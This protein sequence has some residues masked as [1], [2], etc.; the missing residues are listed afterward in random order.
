[1]YMDYFSDPWN[2]YDLLSIIMLIV[3]ICTHIADIASHNES[4]AITHNRL[5][6]V[7]IIIVSLKIFEIGRFLNKVTIL[8]IT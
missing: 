3:V 8:L 7:T 6:A 5:F 1:M 4:I 2:W